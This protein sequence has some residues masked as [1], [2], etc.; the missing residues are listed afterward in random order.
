M[1]SVKIIFFENKS[2]VKYRKVARGTGT[3]G[4]N[5]SACFF[6]LKK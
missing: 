3:C 1:I 6:F 2:T 5:A 4:I